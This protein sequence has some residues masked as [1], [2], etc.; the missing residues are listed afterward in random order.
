M[1]VTPDQVVQAAMALVNT[2]YQHQGRK[3]GIG[4]DCIGVP[5]IVAKNLGLGDFDQTNYNKRP[6]GTLLNKIGKVCHRI[7]LQK[8]ALVVFR[9]SQQAQ[10]CA[11]IYDHPTGGYGIIHAWD[12]AGKVVKHR[13][14]DWKNK[15]VAIYGIPGVKYE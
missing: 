11:I 13:L 8:G 2:P 3:P 5:V 4:V 1:S 6:D 15:I 14:M 7:R 10:H 9:I 12:I